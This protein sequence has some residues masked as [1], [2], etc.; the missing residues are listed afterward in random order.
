MLRLKATARSA[1]Y[2][3]TP[4][5][6]ELGLLTQQLFTKLLCLE[7]KRTERSRRGFVLMLLDPGKLLHQKN[8]EET[9]AKILTALSETIRD[10]DLT[11]WYKDGEVL[12]VIFTEVGTDV[13]R[14]LV[15]T[16]STKVTEAL[17]RTLTVGQIN[18]IKLTF[19]VFP[20][21]W[22]D[23]SP[24]GPV[25]STLHVDLA[26]GFHRNT[27][28]HHAKRLMDIAGS[29]A[30]IF[31]CLPVFIA[32]AAAV[33]FTSRGPILYRQV[34][35]GQYGRKFT[36]LKFRSMHFKND[37][38]IHQQYVKEF[39]TGGKD[40]EPDDLAS[41]KPYKLIADPRVTSVGAFLRKT[42]LDE[43]PQFFN[44]LMGEMSLVGP[45]P[46]VLYEY[47][48]YDLWHK[49]RLLAVKPGIT[50][51]WQVDGRSRVTFD[52]MVRLDIRYAKSWSLWLDIK[53][54]LRTPYAVLSAN[55]AH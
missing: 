31:L 10:T 36:F 7:R 18:E 52:E 17:Y 48:C 26:Q 55:G 16:L 19:H 8:R 14:P 40:T 43:L 54:L 4:G 24:A 6:S 45:R 2:Q 15:N 53:L 37:P 3:S 12:G 39:I 42:S 25:N 44:V 47:E 49:Q 1:P 29:L 32:I 20:E 21:D 50:G 34:R 51:L 23:D 27:M 22:D 5:V 41:P 28:A 30:A 9:L 11:G 46:P 38:S 33:K 35:L 13:G